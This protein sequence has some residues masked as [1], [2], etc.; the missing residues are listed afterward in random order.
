M[1]YD[2]GFIIGLKAFVAA[3]IGGLVSY[4]VTAIGALAVGL[5]ES[6]ASFWSGALKDV[7]VFS[8]LIPVLLLRSL[9][10]RRMPRRR[11]RRSRHER[12]ARSRLR[13]ACRR[14]S[15][16][17]A[18][19][20]APLCSAASPSSLL[21]DIGIG[22]LVALGLVL[23]TGVGGAH[24]VRPGG[25][26]RHRRLR[27][28]LADDGARRLAV[29]RAGRSRSLLTGLVGAGHRRADACAWAAT[30]CRSAPSPGACRSR[31]LFGNIDA[32]GRHNGI[33]EHAADLRSAGWS[34]ATRARST[35]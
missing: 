16:L 28:G 19:A 13:A 21:N 10:A 2:S 29:A 31:L 17:A 18:L 1:Y 14:A 24:L 26:R 8:L 4:P 6:F 22:A 7:I 20:L 32:L 23:L 34:L 12:A 25:L 15:S 9:L 27:H 33:V 30:S 5:V 3:I 11:T 35:T